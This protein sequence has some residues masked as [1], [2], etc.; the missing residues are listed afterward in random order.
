[1]PVK[2]GMEKKVLAHAA[3]EVD[4][5]SA[6]LASVTTSGL[7]AAPL[8]PTV[9]PPAGRVW[10]LPLVVVAKFQVTP[11]VL[12]LQPVWA[13]LSALVVNPPAWVVLVGRFTA[14]MVTG[15]EFVL[16]MVT[17]TSPVLP[18]TARCRGRARPPR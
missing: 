12:V 9:T 11:L 17:T 6:S 3:G 7:F 14:E 10:E 2:A 15:Y 16:A 1:M 4:D 8:A 18:G 5:M 13:V